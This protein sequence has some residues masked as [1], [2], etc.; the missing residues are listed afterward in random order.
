[1]PMVE[2][3]RS[4][5]PPGGRQES[6]PIHGWWWIDAH[7]LLTNFFRRLAGDLHNLPAERG[8]HW[9]IVRAGDEKQIRAGDSRH[10]QVRD[11]IDDERRMAGSAA[12]TREFSA[13]IV[14]WCLSSC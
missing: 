5:M 3:I 10:T 13:S 7:V 2:M 14:S 1:M 6:G 9:S 12:G 8:N 4:A 11:R